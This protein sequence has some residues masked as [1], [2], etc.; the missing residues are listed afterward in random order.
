[1]QSS[2]VLH[3]T[4][5][6]LPSQSL[7]P[8]SEHLVPLDAFWVPHTP[9]VHVLSRH[10]VEGE[11]QSLGFTQATQL[12]LPSQTPWMVLSEHMVPASTGVPTQHSLSQVAWRHVVDL[13]SPLFLHATPPSQLAVPPPVPLLLVLLLLLVLPE[14][15]GAPPVLATPPAPPVDG[16]PELVVDAP[17][18]AD[19]P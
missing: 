9:F 2:G 15:D 13:Q 14:V 17:P 1:M 18:L 6:P 11:G 19:P 3:S 4:H 16:V 12:P 5:A 7:P 10:A 8:S